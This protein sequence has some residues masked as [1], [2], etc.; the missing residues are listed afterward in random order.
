MFQR[1]ALTPLTVLLLLFAPGARAQQGAPPASFDAAAAWSAFEA[2]LQERYGYFDRP[3][4]DGNAILSAF[5]E[6]ARLAHTDQ[7]FIDTLQ[8]VSHNFAD[9]HFV[10]GPL[11]LEDWA[12]I[13]TASD[14]FG[15]HEGTTFRIE[16]VR[17][18][19]DALAKGV[20]PGMVVR[21]LDGRSPRAAV[22]AITGRAF[23][24]LTP[25]QIDFA[26]NVALAGHRRRPRTLELVDGG[27]RRAVALAATSDQAKRVQDGPLLSVERQGSLG[28]LRIHN[29]LGNQA[30]IPEFAKALASVADT[31]T[32][33]IDL[34]NTP[35]GGNT[36]VARG[37]LGHFVDH[38]RPYQVHVVPYESRVLGPPRRFV[39]YVAPFGA[40]YS[41]KVYVAGG[42]W[43]GS[44]GEGLMIGFDA[45]GAT[46]VGSELGDLLGGLSNETIEGSAARIDLG[47][48]QLFTVDGLPREAYRPHLY[49]PRA[50]RNGSHDPVLAA[51]GAQPGS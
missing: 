40:R 23:T 10:V 49:L 45:I 16:E 38:E 32:L 22:E 15:S 36:S 37:I 44:M 12:V 34:R 11:D 25:A 26:F 41:G 28:I 51:I 1:H 5:A 18:E 14:L 7:D 33:L 20:R 2:L 3:G 17:C 19:S 29:A 9:P 24:S 43:T 21:T 4:V 39:E 47:T 30:L 27:H 48:E 6:R 46:T 42:R 8:L 35:S 13:P 50:E 31:R